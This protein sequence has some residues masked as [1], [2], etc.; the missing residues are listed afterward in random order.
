[1]VKTLR[2]AGVYGYTFLRICPASATGA[3]PS[4]ASARGVGRQDPSS[5]GQLGVNPRGAQRVIRR[6]TTRIEGGLIEQPCS[7]V[8][9]GRY[10]PEQAAQ[11]APHLL[12]GLPG[13]PGAVRGMGRL[14]GVRDHRRQP[15]GHRANLWEPRL[16]PL[17]RSY[18]DCVAHSGVVAAHDVGKGIALTMQIA[19][20]V[21]VDVI[22]GVSYGVYRLATR[23]R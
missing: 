23:S 11:E 13:H 3:V 18:S 4:A 14:R 22:L 12:V 8:R 15:C 21:A 2:A 20:W 6:G 5:R 19:L 10:R 7:R 9:T 17:W 16:V 1:V